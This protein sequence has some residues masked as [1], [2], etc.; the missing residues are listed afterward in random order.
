MVIFA[1]FLG[2]Q[3]E[4]HMFL[5]FLFDSS[6]LLQ[7]HNW[8]KCQY[9]VYLLILYRVGFILQK[10]L[11]LD[12]GRF[13]GGKVWIRGDKLM[14]NLWWY[15]GHSFPTRGNPSCITLVNPKDCG[16]A[17]SIIGI[18]LSLLAF[19]LTF[20]PEEVD[21]G[22]WNFAWFLK[23]KNKNNGEDGSRIL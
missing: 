3:T 4:L 13:S 7:P 23:S 14:L 9:V 22:F 1:V 8:C 11:I 15:I 20:L 5:H 17:K 18:C 12:E 21:I 2:W 16:E 6:R 10:S 19:S